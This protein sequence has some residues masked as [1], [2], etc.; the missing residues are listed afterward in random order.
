M[1]KKLEEIFFSI[2]HFFQVQDDYLDCFGDP[3][4]TGKI[5]TDI[6]EGKCTWLVVTAL[7][8]CNPTQRLTIQ[9]ILE[10]LFYKIEYFNIYRFH[11][12]E[13]Y[14]SVIRSTMDYQISNLFVAS[15]KYTMN[16][17]CRFCFLNTKKTITGK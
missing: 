14:F 11:F 16:S 2:G 3:N 13:L 7:N 6:E 10:K 15:K 5:G 17:I 8:V 4:V 12:I 9:V 1:F